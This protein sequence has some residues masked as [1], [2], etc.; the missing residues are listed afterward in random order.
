MKRKLNTSMATKFNKVLQSR[1]MQGLVDPSTGKLL[2]NLDQMTPE[3]IAI[4]RNMTGERFD[5]LPAEVQAGM[6][7]MSETG[8]SSKKKNNGNQKN[9]KKGTP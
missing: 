3:Q 9:N 5:T 8:Q 4:L 6:M 7:D 2:R 1:G